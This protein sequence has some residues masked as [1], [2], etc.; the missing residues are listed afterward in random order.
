LPKEREPFRWFRV[1][2][3]VLPLAAA[4][5][6]FL[7]PRSLDRVKGS[8]SSLSLLREGE[9]VVSEVAPG[10]RLSVAVGAAG[11]RQVLVEAIGEDGLVSGVWPPEGDRS[12]LAPRGAAAALSPPFAV[13]P[14]SVVLFA[15]FSD[16]PIDR[17]DAERALRAAVVEARDRG[18]P[19]V[20]AEP[21]PLPH[22]VSRARRQLCVR[23]SQCSPLP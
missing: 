21:P 17:P 22:E 13:T 11:A 2:W 9:P 4:A 15:F 5:A 23:G 3:L 20:Q 19:A 7:L 6:F 12:G 1:S 18:R 10:E 14:G 8:A 16:S